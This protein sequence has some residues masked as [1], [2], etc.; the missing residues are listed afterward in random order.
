MGS[1]TPSGDSFQATLNDG[2][3]VRFRPIRPD[4]KHWL[5]RGVERMSAE[6]RYRRFFAPVDHLS[7][8]QLRY[9]T[10]VDQL[11]HV[12]W[13]ATLADHPEHPAVAVA[14]FVRVPGHPEAA[15]AAVTVIDQYQGRGLGRAMLVVITREAIELEVKRFTM[16]V[17]GENQA[18]MGLLHAAG[19]VSD[20]TRDG[21]YQMHVDLPDRV[22][23]LDESAAPR[24]L[25]VAAAGNLAGE[26]A[27]GM[28]WNRRPR[29]P[30]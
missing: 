7:D 13:V 5:Q 12:A 3:R 22:E 10:E 17:L 6:S 28:L 27:P 23:D 9:F 8:E 14:R 16:F 19:A 4:D 30:G 18:M 11:D 24:V 2:T 29:D 15:E 1:P 21:V 26:V 20:D 25:R